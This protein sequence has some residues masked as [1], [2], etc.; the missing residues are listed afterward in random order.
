MPISPIVLQRRHAE[1]GRIRTGH[2][3][4]K[5]Q[6]VKLTTFRF[7]SPNERYIKDIAT[8]YGGTAREWDNSGKPEWEVYTDAKSIPV[9]AIKGGISQWMETWS[10][11]GCTHRC[12]GVNLAMKGDTFE[13]SGPL[14][15]LND[16]KHQA[17]KPYTRL[18]VMLPELEAIGVWRLESHGYNA[19]AELPNAAELAAHV[20]D[21][22]KANLTL[23]ERR[24]VSDGRTNRF[25]V[26]VLDLEISQRR[27]VQ[28]AEAMSGHASQIGGAPAPGGTKQI[29]APRV[30]YAALIAQ[31][32]SRDDL[33]TIWRRAGESGDLTDD[34]KAAIVA[35]GDELQPPVNEDGS[36]DADVVDEDPPAVQ[37]SDYDED[38]TNAAW[39]NVVTVAGQNGWTMYDL[40]DAFAKHAGVPVPDATGAQISDFLAALRRGDVKAA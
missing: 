35:R 21:M 6:P 8:L 24:T 4:N 13:A 27:L 32:G 26:P 14:C 30:D 17:A 12:D 36:V 1:L 31:A 33:N 34:L 2:K 39:M 25:V 28:L 38:E 29:E 3:G 11:G 40:E 9:L 20:G 5:G 7:T 10:G 15:D 37:P 23:V 18:S 19:A 16:P 22:V